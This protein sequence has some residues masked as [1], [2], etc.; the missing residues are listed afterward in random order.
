MVQLK[1]AIGDL[2]RIKGYRNELFYVDTIDK[3]ELTTAGGSWQEI[4]LELTSTA[5]DYN[6]AYLEDVVLVCRADF[7]EEYLR[8][9]NLTD[10]MIQSNK[11]VPVKK[12]SPNEQERRINELLDEALLNISAFEATGINDF[13]AKEQ[14]AYEL[15]RQ[16]QRGVLNDVE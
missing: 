3:H 7:A 16:L 2:V 11:E 4:E 5:G 9:G 10:K 13:R 12:L 15:I 8:T 6:F 1:L 14:A